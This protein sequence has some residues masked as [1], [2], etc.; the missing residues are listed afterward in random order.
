MPP[1]GK[2]DY[3]RHDYTTTSLGNTTDICANNTRAAESF[4]IH[5]KIVGKSLKPEVFTANS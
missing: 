3:A 4:Q 1:T 2:I 5:G